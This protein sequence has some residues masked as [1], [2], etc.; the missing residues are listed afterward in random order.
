V[1]LLAEHFL[2]KYANQEG[3]EIR[4]FTREALKL[5]TEYDWPGNVRELENAIERAVVISQGELITKEDLPGKLVNGRQNL[6]KR[7]F[8]DLIPLEELKNQYTQMVLEKTKGNKRMAAR[9]LGINPRTLYRKNKL[10]VL[11]TPSTVN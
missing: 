3:R 2:R 5:L 11:A 10:G 8:N 9:I 4:G 6:V 1:C 7:A